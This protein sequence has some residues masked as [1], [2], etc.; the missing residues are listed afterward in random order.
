MIL[1]RVYCF[2]V[3][4]ILIA[5]GE[6]L[7]Q[8]GDKGK[9]RAIYYISKTLLDYDIRY[10]LIEKMYFVMIFLTKKISH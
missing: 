4:V 3:F 9:E 6:M 8:K 1:K 10:T 7:A 2:F 5:L